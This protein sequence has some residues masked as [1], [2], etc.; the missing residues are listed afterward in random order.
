MVCATFLNKFL[1]AHNINANPMWTWSFRQGT[2]LSRLALLV[3]G[4][5]GTVYKVTW[6]FEGDEMTG[7]TRASLQG[8]RMTAV[9]DHENACYC[10]ISKE[11]HRHTSCWE[12]CEHWWEIGSF[13]SVL[14]WSLSKEMAVSHCGQLKTCPSIWPD[15][16]RLLSEQ[17][18]C[19]EGLMLSACHGIM[20][21]KDS[22]TLLGHIPG[23]PVFD[24]HVEAHRNVINPF[25][26]TWQIMYQ[27]INH[28]K[29]YVIMVFWWFCVCMHK[30]ERLEVFVWNSHPKFSHFKK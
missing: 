20:E 30:G 9:S 13:S 19:C 1:Y 24:G 22:D 28:N 3:K 12:N 25:E 26:D 10:N 8:L 17:M 2:G 14:T 5:L 29:I 18:S 16:A 23:L 15:C 11:A 27:C 6:A 21:P 7:A 4:N